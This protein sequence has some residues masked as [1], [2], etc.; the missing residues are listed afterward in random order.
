MP[1]NSVTDRTD[2]D[3]LIPPDTA[4][5]I[6]KHITEASAVLQLARRRPNIPR[7]E[8]TMPVFSTKP[9]AY[10]VDGDTGYVQTTEA[11]WTNV[12][13]TAE[14]LSVII[15]IPDNVIADSEYDLWGEL[16]PEV[17]EAMGVAIDAAVLFGT[18]KPSSWPT[19]LVT[20][21][22]AK[23]QAVD[24]STTIAGGG[25]LY[26]AILG[27][28]GVHSLLEVDG[29]MPTGQIAALTLRAKIRGLRDANGQPI[30]ARAPESRTGYTLDGVDIAFPKNGAFDAAT[31]LLVAGQWDELVWA[32]REDMTFRIYSEGVV[33]NDSG[34]VQLN[35]MQQN[36]KALK[37][38]M[39]LGFALPNPVNRVNSNSTTRYP[40]ATLVP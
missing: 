9:T 8:H 25:D 39:R 18:N 34:I 17:E 13:L 16:Q 10:F 22:A 20:A 38:T 4:K 5:E 2:V 21:A 23:S 26:D 12:T 3:K 29:F 24:L 14:M 33:T 40:F 15:P 37:V 1:Y 30:F 27:E 11:A 19:A 31:A 32:L 6:Q 28:N 7:K 35:L 36:A